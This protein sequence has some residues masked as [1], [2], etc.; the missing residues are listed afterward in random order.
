MKTSNFS[1]IFKI[2]I[3]YSQQI[4]ILF[5]STEKIAFVSLQDI[6]SAFEYLSFSNENVLS[7]DCL[8]Q[9]IYYNKETMMIFIEIFN[10]LLPVF[11]SFLS[12]TIW[13][14]LSYISNLFHARR[15]NGN[16]FP[17]SLRDIKA[18]MEIFI[19]LSIFIFYS[20]IVKSFFWLFNCITIDINERDTYLRQSPN[21]LCWGE[22]HLTYVFFV[23]F[24]GLFVWGFG[25]PIFLFLFL[26]RNHKILIVEEKRLATYKSQKKNGVPKSKVYVKEK[27]SDLMVNDEKIIQSMQKVETNKVFVFFYKDF[28]QNFYYWECF[29]FLRKLL[30]TFLSSMRESMPLEIILFC[31]LLVILFS[32]YATINY[33]PFKFKVANMV[34]NFSLILC[35]I[36]IFAVYFY[37]SV[38]ADSL[39]ILVSLIFIFLNSLFLNRKCMYENI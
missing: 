3:N 17:N 26:Q 31:M 18:K 7:N 38:S 23:A 25:F 22:T 34:E 21:V 10:A 8:I 32:L 27:K 14:F 4:T 30:L 29:I 19:F 9:K 2:L 11:F 20:L 16:K 33:S 28:N 35:T 36:T 13:I 39:K 37:N 6:F 24:P 5:F 15:K 12:F 1:C